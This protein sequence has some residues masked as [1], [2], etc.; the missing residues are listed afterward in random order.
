MGITRTWLCAAA[1]A[2]ALACSNDN[3]APTTGGTGAGAGGGTTPTTANVT[4]GNIFFQSARNGTKNPAVDTVATGGTVT[5]T[6]T[7]TGTVAH[8]VLSMGTPSFT[9]SPVLSGDGQTYTMAFSTAG[10][11]Q[12][13]CAV[14]GTQMTGT[15]VVQ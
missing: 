15:I 1:A 6:W 3:T 5:W 8:S 10:T 9:S 11:Y 14:H 2:L 12:Y 7:G 4:V 13:D